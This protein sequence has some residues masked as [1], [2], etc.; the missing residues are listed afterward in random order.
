[1]S[2]IKKILVSCVIALIV[3]AVASSVIK[4]IDNKTVIL[5]PV[6]TSK[7]EEGNKLSDVVYVQV[8]LKN[9]AKDVLENMVKE[10][11]LFKYVAKNSIQ[12][13]ETIIKDKVILKEEYL[14]KTENLEIEYPGSIYQDFEVTFNNEGE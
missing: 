13:G 11:D 2:K 14:E 10:P 8:K 12:K 5:V 4:V 9:V 3:I 1:M 6:A 7:I